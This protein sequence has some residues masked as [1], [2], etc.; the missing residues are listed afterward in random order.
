MD[1]LYHYTSLDGIHGILRSASIW[2]THVSYLNDASEFFHGLSSA[3][4]VAG[5]IFME[6]DYL[7]AFG[8]AVRHGLEAV[9]ADD[10]FVASFSEKADLLSQWRGY[11]PAGA[12]LCL[13]FDVAQLRSF[14]Q[15]RG[16]KLEQCIYM[17]QEQFQRV[18]ALVRK[19]FEVF[20][21]PRLTRSDYEKLDSK[22]QVDAEISYRLQTSEGSD[23]QQADAAVEWLCSEIAEVAPLFKHEGFHEE[24]E[25]RIV[26][27]KPRE[28]VKFRADSSYLAPYVEL[29]ILS[30]TVE[31]ALREVIIGPNPNQRR[32]ETSVKM[33]LASCELTHVEIKASPL[34]FNSW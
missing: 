5:G 22:G 24:A 6:D 13:G 27:K 34:P 25:W 29:E 11:C 7:A 10:L 3:K 8:W 17:H 33:L 12:G 9:S 31:S 18:D 2:A 23:K 30:S 21:K 4:Q 26:A 32:C 20:P 16:Y 19:C 14:C 1:T 15:A 28:P